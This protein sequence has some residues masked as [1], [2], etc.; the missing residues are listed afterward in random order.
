MP[1]HAVPNWP[2]PVHVVPHWPMPELCCYLFHLSIS[3][4]ESTNLT[5]NTE[6]CEQSSWLEICPYIKCQ[7]FGRIFGYMTCSKSFQIFLSDGRLS[8]WDWTG[9]NKQH[10]NIYSNDRSVSLQCWHS[11]HKDFLSDNNIK[12]SKKIETAW[13]RIAWQQM[14][15]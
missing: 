13:K 1:V 4:L 12:L 7:I 8:G 14:Q 10:H 6:T 3:L 15:I 9:R 5:Q 11:F 2:M